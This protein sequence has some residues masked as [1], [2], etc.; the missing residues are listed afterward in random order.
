MDEQNDGPAGECID[1]VVA[2]IETIGVI[3]PPVEIADACLLAYGWWV[4]V[5]RSS[6]AIRVLH[7]QGLGH[8][9]APLV[10]TVLHHTAALVWLARS[11]QQA[12]EAVKWQD[13]QN[14]EKLA[15]LA[16][17]GNWE[18]AGAYTKPEKPIENKPSGVDF[19]ERVEKLCSHLGIPDWYVPFR[20]ESMFVHPSAKG[21]LAYLETGP[22]LWTSARVP[23][24]PLSSTAMFLGR[25]TGAL[26][27]VL[28]SEVIEE[29]SREVG[30]RIGVDVSIPG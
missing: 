15:G 20:I 14:T 17:K 21:A 27:K 29:L 18:F 9:A 11:P 8:E 13:Q 16:H 23:G 10:R 5:V 26:G 2:R 24:T 19:L 28:N 30:T 22:K 12:F 25:A 1:L 4:R 3:S 7:Q 6:Q